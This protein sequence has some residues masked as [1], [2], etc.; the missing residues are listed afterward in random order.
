VSVRCEGWS[1]IF[2]CSSNK[3]KWSSSETPVCAI[4]S[5][6]YCEMHAVNRFLLAKIIKAVE[7]HRELCTLYGKNIMSDSAVRK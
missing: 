5:P 2:A 3:I 6:A 1:D 7:I 4:D